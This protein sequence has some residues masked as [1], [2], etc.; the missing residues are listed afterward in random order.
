MERREWIACILREEVANP[1]YGVLLQ[2][3]ALDDDVLLRE[4]AVNGNVGSEGFVMFLPA[5]EGFSVF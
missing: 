4:R 3:L 2:T 5:L 1:L